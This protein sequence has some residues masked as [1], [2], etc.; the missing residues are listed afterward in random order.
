[1]AYFALRDK[2]KC[3]EYLNQALAD[4]RGKQD[5]QGEA[6]TLTNLASAYG[7][8]VNDSLKS[9]DYF[10]QAITQLELL[11]DRASE[12][13]A[14]QLMGAAWIKLQN[15]DM[16]VQ[17][18]NRALFLYS[19]LGNAQGEASVRRQLSALGEPEAIASAR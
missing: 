2:K 18:F 17:S 19:R 4:Y 14:L 8:L 9:I 12:A 3:L 11:N 7:F 5:R 16:A 13:N 15:P 10:Q 1:L 6:F